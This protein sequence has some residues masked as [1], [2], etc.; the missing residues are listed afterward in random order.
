VAQLKM[1]ELD[2][3][4]K[5]RISSGDKYH[6]EAPLPDNFGFTV[7]SEYT[8]PFDLGSVSGTLQKLYAIGGISA[9]VGLRMRKMYANPEPTE[10]SFEM[11]FA[12]YHS[13]KEDVVV[14]IVT[15]MVMSLGRVI[16]KQ[17]VE[18][19][20]EKFSNLAAQG[21]S[22]A[23]FSPEGAQSAGESAQATINGDNGETTSRI[24]EMINLIAAPDLCTI[25]FGEFLTIDKAYI[26]ST[27]VQF[28]N[29]LDRDGYPMSG[30]VNVT[31]TVQVAPLADDIV[32]FFGGVVQVK[33]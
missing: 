10:I 5:L 1:A 29:I 17:D 3:K 4:H 22:F 7:G 8:T 20:I 6:V 33:R 32:E 9:P 21:A 14:P 31:A 12:A 2:N 11:E 26:T 19:A 15:L 27:A 23:G 30:R 13:A 25:R 24:L 16:T 28:S 18:A